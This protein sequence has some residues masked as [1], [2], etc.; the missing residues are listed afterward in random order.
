[1]HELS[2]AMSL[3]EVATEEAHRLTGRVTAVHLNLGLQSG[4]VKEALLSAYTHASTGSPLRRAPP[5]SSPKFPSQP[6]APPAIANNKSIPS[7][8][9]SAPPAKPQPQ[10][11]SPEETWK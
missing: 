5:S 3:V 9:S 6:G 11:C 1:M 4:V 2:I 10:S 7:N 8:K